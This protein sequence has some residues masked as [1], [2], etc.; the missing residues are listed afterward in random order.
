MLVTYI[1]LCY[2]QEN[3]IGSAIESIINQNY[4]EI[5][6]IVSDDCSTD[7]SWNAISNMSQKNNIKITKTKKKHRVNWKYKPCI[8]FSNR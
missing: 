8:N 2:N 1:L 3:F 4:K 6:I 7:K 5:E